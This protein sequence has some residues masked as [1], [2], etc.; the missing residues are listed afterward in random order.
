NNNQFTTIKTT[1]NNNSNSYQNSYNS[2]RSN[3]IIKNINNNNLNNLNN[4]IINSTIPII[5]TIP[6]SE[7]N[8][9][10]YFTP[11]IVYLWIKN[12]ES[13]TYLT[14]ELNERLNSDFISLEWVRFREYLKNNPDQI[15]DSNFE[16]NLVKKYYFLNY[17]YSIE[18]IQAISAIMFRSPIYVKGI[19]DSLD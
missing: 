13:I 17:E 12:L 16:V 2:R 9:K 10:S 14:Q 4:L 5:P 7:Y 11:R 8:L 6:I 18:L 19:W 15:T 3:R 1:N